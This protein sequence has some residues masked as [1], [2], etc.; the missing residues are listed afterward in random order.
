MSFWIICQLGAREHYAIPRALHQAGKLH[1]LVTDAWVTPS[2]K[3]NWVPGLRSLCDRHHLDLATASIKTFTPSLIHFEATHRL[4]KTAPWERMMARNQWFQNRALSY[5]DS[6]KN[7]GNPKPVLFAYSYAALDLL[8]YAKKRGW[9]TVL[10]QIDPGIAEE[11]IVTAEHIKY[12][13][14]APNWKPV[15]PDYWSLWQQECELADHIVVNSAWSKQLL[16][17]ATVDP[18]KIEI[19]SLVYTPPSSAQSFERTYPKSFSSERPL[20]VLF[21]GLVTLRKG[22]AALI[23]AVKQLEGEPIEFWIVGA[24]EIRIPE[25]MKN[26]PQIRWI[27]PVPRSQVQTYYRQADVFL[28]PTLSDG[29]G[30]TQLEA[31]AWHLPIIASQNCGE[32][33]RDG[34]NGIVLSSTSP[35]DIALSLRAVYQEP[36]RLVT[37]AQQSNRLPNFSLSNLQAALSSIVI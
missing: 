27:G 11:K 12:P 35:L 8:R 6:V 34:I 1:S 23:E 20:R 22:I 9:R 29:F 5:L 7:F 10:G 25:D 16:I 13:S 21:L 32:V 37:Y 28:F 30:L 18:R 2:S 15:P 14:L 19:V 26:H 3:L 24:Q 33:V 17:Q 36:Q 31:Q 4:Q